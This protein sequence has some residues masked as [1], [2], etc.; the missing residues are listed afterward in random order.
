MTYLTGYFRNRVKP[1]V[2]VRELDNERIS[3]FSTLARQFNTI[4]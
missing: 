2:S 4:N 1:L 3:E